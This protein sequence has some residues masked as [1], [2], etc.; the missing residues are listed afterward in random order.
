MNIFENTDNKQKELKNDSKKIHPDYGLI[1]E[2]LLISRF[3]TTEQFGSPNIYK[4]A[5]LLF[6][7]LYSPEDIDALVKPSPKFPDRMEIMKKSLSKAIQEIP[8]KEEF[9]KEI[10]H[11]MTN[12]V[13]FGEC[14]S[15]EAK[16]QFKKVL[17]KSEETVIWTDGDSLGVPE[18]NLPGSK[19][20]LKKIASAKF[21]NQT[22]REVA[23]EKGMDHKDVLSIAAIEGKIELIPQIVENFKKRGISKMIIVED[24]IKNIVNAIKLIKETDENMQVFPVWIRVGMYKNKKEEGRNLEEWARELHAIENISELENILENN[25]VFE[26]NVKVGSVFD[27]DGPLHDDDKRKE[28][29]TKA[30]VE[31]LKKLNWI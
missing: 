18:K 5:E 12:E 20:Q 8:N 31:K 4:T 9:I 30:V 24:R 15:E 28:I 16:K 14:L 13:D 19:E 7:S 27:L 22:R 26:N 2:K 6:A 10:R 25:S 21:Y 29:Q 1:T 23:K 11:T 3:S 17:E